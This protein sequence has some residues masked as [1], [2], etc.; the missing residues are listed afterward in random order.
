[1]ILYLSGSYT[2]FAIEQGYLNVLVSY[3]YQKKE[4]VALKPLARNIFLDSGAFSAH[5][6]GE[7][8]RLINYISFIHTHRYDIYAGL[9][10]IGNPEATK[11]NI[12]TMEEA[13]LHPIPT[14]HIGSNMK[15]LYEMLEKYTHIA[16]GGM[17]GANVSTKEMFVFLDRVFSVIYKQTSGIKAH[18][19]ACSGREV[20]KNY[21][22]HSVDSTSWMGSVLFAR[23]IDG[24][25]S[26]KMLYNEMQNDGNLV[27]SKKHQR[28]FLLKKSIEEYRTLEHT[29]TEYHSKQ[30]WRY[31]FTKQQELFV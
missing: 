6:S 10:V 11:A 19:F 25:S 8:I 28:E 4:A 31:K 3:H 22:W 27:D 14:F 24:V 1:M 18:G 15:Y 16:L 2:P 20:M 30:D 26:K 7:T 29:I 5:N 21:P 13:G 17:A 23:P 9:D 12:E